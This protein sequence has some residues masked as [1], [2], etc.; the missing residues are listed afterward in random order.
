MSVPETIEIDGVRFVKAESEQEV[1]SGLECVIARARDAGVFVGYLQEESADTN[2]VVL[3]NAR[4]LW[5]WAGAAT[6]SQLSQE[7]VKLPDQCKFPREVPHVVL[8]NVCELLP[9]T[10]VAK[11]SIDKVK[12]WEK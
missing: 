5:Y 9:V 11:A 8:F 3:R 2:R 7:G 6:L 10:Q 4:R 12:V 1:A